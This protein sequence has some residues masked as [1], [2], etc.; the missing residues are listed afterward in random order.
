MKIY[1]NEKKQIFYEGQI[2]E[3]YDLH[4]NFLQEVRINKFIKH[5]KYLAVN[6]NSLK[7]KTKN[8]TLDINCIGKTYK[9]KRGEE[10]K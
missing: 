8:W 7:F 10:Q 5:K 6:F 9:A 4:G 1:L 3:E 2:L